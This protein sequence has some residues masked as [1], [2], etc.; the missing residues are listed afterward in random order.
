MMWIE[1]DISKQLLNDSGVYIQILVGPRQCGKSSL[2]SFLSKNKFREVTFDDLQLRILANQDPALFLEQHKPPL[3]IDEVQYAPNIFPELKKIVDELKK[4]Q[5]FFGKTKKSKTIFRLT[6]SNQILMDKQV[7]ESLVGRANY[8]YLNTLSVNEIKKAFPNESIGNIMFIGG[9][10][11]LYTNKNISVVRYLNDYIRNYIEKDIVLSAGVQKQN[12]FHT[13][14]GMLA[15]RTG[16]LLNYSAV[17]NNS[18]VKSITIKEWASILEKT[19]LIYLLKPY[20]NNLNKRLVKIPKLYFLDTGLA[21]RLQGWS[22]PEPF[23]KNP[24]VGH[25]FETLVLS[26]IIKCM[27]NYGKNWN[28]YMWRTK[29]G[30]EIDFVI[31]KAN[32]DVLALDA[33]MGIHSVEP[34]S[35]PKSFTNTFKNVKQLILVSFGGKKLFLTKNCMQLP[36][37]KL[38]DFLRNF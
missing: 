16:E 37:S 21:V 38:T 19:N 30:E 15:A 26:E 6:G 22:E 20:A 3:I 5:L 32:G 25:I 23:M 27:N 11:E 8:Y 18:G 4:Q 9:W 14:L 36:I 24:Y 31:E 35:L 13:V 28:V 12:E 2:L 10:P 7:K 1:R 17:A 33:K 29:D 34:K